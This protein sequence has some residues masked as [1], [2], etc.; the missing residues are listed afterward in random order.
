M[1]ESA[2]QINVKE[3][4]NVLSDRRDQGQRIVLFLGASTGALFGNKYLYELLNQ[5][6]LRNFASLS[7]AVKFAECYANLSRFR[8]TERHKILVGAMAALSYREE[9][10]I[11]AQLVK[12]RFFEI[13]ISTNIDTLLEDACNFWGMQKPNDYR[14]LIPGAYDIPKIGQ[15]K[16]GATS[17]I[18]VFGDLK[19]K[20]YK[21]VDRSLD[22]YSELKNFLK[23]QLTKE[24]LVIGYDPVW[25]ESLERAFPLTGGTIWYANEEKA[26][27]NS[28][29][30]SL[31]DRRHGKFLQYDQRSYST[32][33]QVLSQYLAK[34]TKREEAAYSP[35]LRSPDQDTKRVFISCSSQDSLYLDRLK[36]HLKGY[37]SEDTLEIWNEAK[38]A[39]GSDGE[40]EIKSALTQAKVAI[41][42]ISSNFLDSDFVREKEIP[43]LLQADRSGNVRLLPIIIDT[44]DKS[45]RLSTFLF[46]ERNALNDYQVIN[47]SSTPLK[48]MKSYEQEVVWNKLAEQVYDILHA[49]K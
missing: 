38:I 25:D 27:A 5:F 1:S 36:I 23:K 2:T 11:L 13:V 24:V 15:D 19:S 32:L 28:R 29:F 41:V 10:K 45:F 6:S 35:M 16:A 31:L 46:S 20:D 48:P 44:S 8:E 33:L 21:I 49:Q 39:A 4:A 30:A 7:N 26:S 9:D 22:P 37:M 42:L 34:D 3:M 14:V 12:M 40:E 18:K 47:S 17:I 43:L